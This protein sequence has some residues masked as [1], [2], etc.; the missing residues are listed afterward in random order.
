MSFGILAIFISF[1]VL[2]FVPLISE[3]VEV[4]SAFDDITFTERI[5]VPLSGIE[6]FF[7]ENGLTQ[8]EEGFLVAEINNQFQTIISQIDLGTVL[9][10][11][12]SITGTVFIGF[13]AIFFITF[14]SCPIN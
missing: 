13:L 2:L 4:I 7:I 9:N 12:L 10:D 1:F 6:N 14:F 3:Q 8:A 11:V 5:G